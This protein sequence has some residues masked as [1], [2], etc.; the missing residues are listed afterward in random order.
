MRFRLPSFFV[1]LALF[2]TACA[3]SDGPTAPNA[4]QILSRGAL[5]PAAAV[6]LRHQDDL[7]AVP[8]VVGVGLG[9][10][11]S[12]QPAIVI[13]AERS[14]VAGLPVSLGGVPVRVMVTGEIW[15]LQQDARKCENPPNCGGGGGGGG[16]GGGGDV[17]PTMRFPRPVPIGVSTGHPA[18]TAGTIGCR[19]TDGTNVFALSN[20]H[21]YADANAASIGDDAVIQ[22]GTFDGGSS[23]DDDIGTLSA[24][25][26]IVFSLAANNVVDAAIAASSTANLDNATPSNGYGTPKSTTITAA[27]NMRVMK[28][29][30]TTQQTKGRVQAINATVNV[31][32]GGPGLARFV[33]Q[34]VIG[35]GGFSAGGDSGSLIVVEKGGDK[36]KPVGLLFAGSSSVTIANP[37]DPVLNAFGVTVDGT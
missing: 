7:M 9:A 34:I 15:A 33:N 1:F 30:R 18:I 23:P 26:P 27:V 4:P 36:L 11:E 3:E 2:I 35:G 37:I 14:G 5:A 12:G 6:Q 19:V 28:Y 24:F 16:D 31:N 17:D 29:G 13:L 32:Y 8:G 21:V 25:V 22:P 20:N 10:T